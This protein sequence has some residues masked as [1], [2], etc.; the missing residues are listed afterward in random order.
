M[1]RRD[2][3]A[4][5]AAAAAARA[6]SSPGSVDVVLQALVEELERSRTLRIIG[7][8]KPYYFEY[9]LHDGESFTAS[10]SLGALLRSN[11][12]RYRIPRIQVRTGD[13]Q[14][15]N[16]N[17]IATDFIAGPR[18][19]VESFPTDN[20]PAALRRHLWLATDAAYKAAVEA[21]SRKRS[22]LK[23]VAAA[24]DLPDFARAE[25]VQ[26]LN[27]V[28]PIRFDEQA[29]KSSVKRISAVFLDF[30]SVARRAWSCSPA[31]ARITWR[32]PKERASAWPR[33]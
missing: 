12:S 24:P 26:L 4:A 31:G 21:I 32:H 22:A 15:D 28:R 27:E 1:N 8:D 18:Y 25:P 9:A 33:A 16:T 29:G 10:A 17:Y 14:F 20:S 7:V 13:Y 3:L 2:F 11:R 19:D 30:P 23:N 6:Q 5:V